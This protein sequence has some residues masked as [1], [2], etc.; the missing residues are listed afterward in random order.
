M[1]TSWDIR[2]QNRKKLP[3]RPFPAVEQDNLSFI[4]L[5]VSYESKTT[6]LKKVGETV[7]AATLDNR[8]SKVISPEVAYLKLESRNYLKLYH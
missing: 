4:L 2:P 5:P 7:N 6:E 8:L 3:P 1:I